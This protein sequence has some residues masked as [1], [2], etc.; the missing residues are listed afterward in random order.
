MLSTCNGVVWKLSFQGLKWQW[1]RRRQSRTFKCGCSTIP[2]IGCAS[3]EV[4]RDCT[5]S[6]AVHVGHSLC[7]CIGSIKTL[8]GE[9]IMRL[10]TAKP[11]ATGKWKWASLEP[12]LYTQIHMGQARNVELGPGSQVMDNG[13]EEL[14]EAPLWKR[15][16]WELE[17][18][19]EDFKLHKF[20][21]STSAG[22]GMKSHVPSP[23]ANIPMSIVIVVAV[24]PRHNAAN[25]WT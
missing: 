25:V 8:L 6:H 16:A 24:A 15:L 17:P 20:R 4:S 18:G 21:N 12:H 22:T 19:M 13:S 5:Q 9:G 11:T 3:Q 14:M 10:S 23:H 7:K 2:C 1:W